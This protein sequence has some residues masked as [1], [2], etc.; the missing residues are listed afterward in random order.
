MQWEGR[1]YELCWVWL[2]HALI[3]FSACPQLFSFLVVSSSEVLE[4]TLVRS[5]CDGGVGAGV[6]Y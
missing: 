2:L 5:S 3:S 1:F 6:G 4:L